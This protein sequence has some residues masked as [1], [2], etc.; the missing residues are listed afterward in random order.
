MVLAFIAS[1]FGRGEGYRRLQELLDVVAHGVPVS[2]KRQADFEAEW[3]R[4]NYPL[5]PRHVPVFDCKVLEDIAL[6][7]CVVMHAAI[8][9]MYFSTRLHINPVFVVD[10]G[11]AKLRV[12][13]DLSAL[14]HGESV[15][16]TTVFEEAPVVECGH[17]FEA[18]LYVWTC[19]Y[20][21]PREAG[22]PMQSKSLRQ[23]SSLVCAVP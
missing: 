1:F 6:G 23:R 8:A 13:H 7:R 20:K 4:G 22:L 3:T 12:V 9:R 14:L 10:E 5:E 11:A 2:V 15:N 21:G 19:I 17:I 16:N 18:M